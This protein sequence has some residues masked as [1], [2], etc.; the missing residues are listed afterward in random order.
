M[1]LALGAVVSPTDAVA[2]NAIVVFDE[3]WQYEGF[4]EHEMRALAESAI[5]G[6]RFEWIVRSHR[7]GNSDDGVDRGG[8]SGG[9]RRSCC[10]RGGSGRWRRRS[11]RVHQPADERHVVR[12]Q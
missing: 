8:Q 5:E 12:L 3:I 4:E 6:L 10:C 7:D 11:R 1:A 2:V 9:C